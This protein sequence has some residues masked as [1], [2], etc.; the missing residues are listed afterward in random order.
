[1]DRTSLLIYAATLS[2]LHLGEAVDCCLRAREVALNKMGGLRPKETRHCLSS[3]MHGYSALEAVAN[4]MHFE[5]FRNVDG[6]LYVAVDAK[7]IPMR[8]FVDRERWRD[9][10]LEAKL[11]FLLGRVG[12][13]QRLTAGDESKV[14][15]F[16]KYRH[17]VAHGLVTKDT[18]LFGAS[19]Y[20]GFIDRVVDEES[21]YDERFKFPV[22]NLPRPDKLRFNGARRI[23]TVVLSSVLRICVAYGVT[24]PVFSY[25]MTDLAMSVLRRRGQHEPG[26]DE[27][28]A[29]LA[30]MPAL[31]EYEDE[32]AD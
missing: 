2:H 25:L 32:E 10:A 16:R 18:V 11:Q 28:T 8:A 14:R 15:E 1:M 21:D 4:R 27:L 9:T 23:L 19:E 30:A 31:P 20:D 22:L 17:L 13:D 6:H 12:E 3:V 24:E 29:I 5:I 26:P 7:D